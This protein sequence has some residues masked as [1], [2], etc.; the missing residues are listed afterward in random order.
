[1]EVPAPAPAPVSPA[2]SPQV[3][4]P[5]DDGCTIRGTAGNDRL[6]GTSRADVICGLGGDDVLLGKGGNDRIVGGPGKDRL[7]GG[8]GRDTLEARDGAADRLIGG[9]GRDR[10]ETDRRGDSLRSIERVNGGLG[11]RAASV[12][13]IVFHS[14]LNCSNR[15]L[16]VGSGDMMIYTPDNVIVGVRDYVW[17]WTQNGWQFV[18]ADGW[19][20]AASTGYFKGSDPVWYFPALDRTMMHGA[21]WTVT[22]SGYMA[23]SQLIRV[24]DRASLQLV[25]SSHEWVRPIH[26]STYYCRF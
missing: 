19:A 18:T 21:L 3:T 24:W 11:A 17:R 23:V 13:P 26:D 22:G 4:P 25:S 20:Y 6:V 12:Q 2:P 1:V 7:D 8:V 5:P 10:A 16:L 9:S 14:L 15:Q